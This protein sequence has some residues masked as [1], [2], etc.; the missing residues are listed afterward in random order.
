M[1]TIDGTA[2]IKIPAGIQNGTK[3]RLK[4]KGVLNP[5]TNERGD[6]YVNI[7]ISMP[8]KLSEAEMKKF[9][10]LS[11][12]TKYNPRVNLDRYIR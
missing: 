5:K 11:E 2:S 7:I 4:G 10:E 6:Q 8:E 9:E 3:L 1:P 12:K